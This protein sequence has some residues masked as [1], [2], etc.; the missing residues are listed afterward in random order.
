MKLHKAPGIDNIT[1][2]VLKAGG[3]P[4][5]EMLVKIFNSAW[6]DKSIPKDWSKMIVT[7]VYKKGDKLDPANYR[8]ISLLSIPGKVFCK[9]LLDRIKLRA[10]DLM[11]ESQFGFRPG[12][13]T[14]DA[15]F[16]VRQLIENAN[17]HKVPLHF[18]FIDFKAAFDTIWRKALWKM[19]LAIGVDPTVVYLI[20]EMYK[21]TE[22]AVTING[23]LTEWFEVNV[24]VRQGCLLSPTLFN[25]FLE[26]VMKELRSHTNSSLALD[27]NL[28][29]D[30]RYADDT[31]LISCIFEKL[32]LS[33]EALETAC[34]KWGMKIN[35]SK[36][37]ILSSENDIDITIDGNPIEHVNN[38][39]FLGS[40]IPDT[41]TEIE[42]RIG[43]ASSAFGRLKTTIWN[44]LSKTNKKHASTIHSFCQL[45]CMR[46]RQECHHVRY[47]KT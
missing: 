12:R 44:Q 46:P 36:C 10:E 35:S 26:F 28:T 22:C 1:A 33:S 42:R 13:G 23:Q 45:Y 34:K 30:I 29:N 37:K 15:I 9:I 20:E 24:G 38:F 17:E 43:I 47:Q 40:N 8:A 25:I 3:K 16:I 31:T 11:S 2:E 27:N 39:V 7:P 32:K 14:V 19:M 18:N 5:C 41:S 6:K 4:M 21:T